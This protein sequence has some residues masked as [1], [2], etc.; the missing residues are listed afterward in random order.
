MSIETWL[1]FLAASA[2][3]LIIPGPTIL[4]VL[5]QSL[6]GGR[7]STL[8]L[9]L[10]VAAGDALAL[11]L[12]LA[13]LGALLAASALAFTVLRWAGAAYLI[14]LGI[15]MWR[16]PVEGAPAPLPPRRAGMQAFI[17][18]ATNPKSIAFFVAFVPQFLDPARP[19]LLQA[20]LLVASFV[21]LGAANALGYA[22]LAG[23]LS[24]VVR[25]PG[26]RQAMNRI[27]G[28]MLIGAGMA[29]ALLGRRA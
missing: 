3:M 25:R 10:G 27:G 12:S 2:A 18:T 8:P 29:T 22:L 19:F 16:A 14:W 1:A 11:S 20:A 28:S 23:R 5:G 13:G 7:R 17:V 24:G 6:G 26:P 9:V 15:R 21:T 4:L